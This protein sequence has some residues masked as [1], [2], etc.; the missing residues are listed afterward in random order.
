MITPEYPPRCGG[1]GYYVSSLV[2]CLVRKEIAVDLYVREKHAYKDSLSK[3]VNVNYIKVVGIPP[4]NNNLLKKNLEKAI[5]KTNYNLV[6]IHSVS[7]PSLNIP[8]PIV[9][10]SHSCIK[11]IIPLFYRPITSMESFYRNLM[12]SLYCKVEKK[13]IKNCDILTV[14]SDSMR[15]DYKKAYDVDSTVVYNGVDTDLFS[16]SGVK[17]SKNIV[18]AGA[19]K[20]GKGLLDLLKAVAILSQ[21]HPDYRYYFYGNGPLRRRMES[22]I[23]KAQ[24]KNVFLH[25]HVSHNQ[26]SSILGNAA[27]FV[28]PSYYEGLPNSILEAMA[29]EVPVVASNVKGNAELVKENINGCLFQRGNCEE[30]AQK[31]ETLMESPSLRASMGK[32]GRMIVLENFTWDKAAERFIGIYSQFGK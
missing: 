22:M 25:A 13:L 28:L 29:C 27:V 7:M 20:H 23:H 4:F 14:V 24:F 21:K 18:Y 9:I 11:E 30:L 6:H 19:L 3:L 15:A 2:K 8:Y 32:E 1:I 17:G 31:L 5:N 16:P 10:T 12:Y 26:L